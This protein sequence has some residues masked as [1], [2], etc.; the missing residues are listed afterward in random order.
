MAIYHLTTRGGKAHKG[1]AVRHVEY[2]S[3]EGRYS[4]RD[5][6]VYSE[7]GNMP[8]WVKDDTKTFWDSCDTLERTNGRAYREFELALPRELPHKENIDLVADFVREQLGTLHAYEWA[9]HDKNDGNPHAH[10]MF[11]ERMQDGIDRSREQYFKRANSKA[12]ER[13]GCPKDDGWRGTRGNPPVRLNEARARW[14][15]LQNIHLDRAGELARVDHRSLWSQE[16]DRRPQIH[17][18]FQDPARPEIHQERAE[19]N[20]M[21]KA[22]NSIPELI[23]AETDAVFYLEAVS[24]ELQLLEKKISAPKEEKQ[25]HQAEKFENTS[26]PNLVSAIKPDHSI[27]D[28]IVVDR[29]GAASRYISGYSEERTVSSFHIEEPTKKTEL[30]DSEF[31]KEWNVT[32][33]QIIKNRRSELNKE[34]NQETERLKELRDKREEER[35]RHGNAYPDKPNG[36]LSVFKRASYERAVEEWKQKDNEIYKWY[37]S[38]EEEISENRGN[39]TRKT[40]DYQLE[41]YAKSKLEKERPEDAQRIEVYEEQERLKEAQAWFRRTQKSRALEEINDRENER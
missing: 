32:K 33:S 25:E 36:L 28:K 18:G 24:Y 19:Y 15:D 11:S 13:G 29:S 10:I 6:L 30:S 5:D 35:K 22:A 37:H 2:I 7:A 39:L 20:E 14:A 31:A 17:V 38:R 8:S 27:S 12:P 21:I 9:I 16:I 40:R 23:K 34:I 26:K 3:R 4:D 41:L 1:N